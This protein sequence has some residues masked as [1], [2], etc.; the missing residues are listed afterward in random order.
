MRLTNLRV[1]VQG[2]ALAGRGVEGPVAGDGAAYADLGVFRQVAKGAR[3]GVLVRSN[4]QAHVCDGVMSE[5]PERRG[6]GRTM[7]GSGAP[8]VRTCRVS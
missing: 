5:S 6:G 1:R 8:D 7:G 3:T 2:E 4:R